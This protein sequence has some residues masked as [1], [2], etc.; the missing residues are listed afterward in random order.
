MKLRILVVT[1]ISALGSGCSTLDDPRFA[2]QIQPLLSI[3]HGAPNA[4]AFYQLGRYYQ[5]QFRLVQAEEAYLKAIAADDHYVDA[6]NA[7]GSLYAERGDLER[8]AKMFEQVT[9][10][11]PN[12]AYLYNNLGFAYYL[13]GRFEEAYVNVRKALSLDGSIERGWVNLERIASMFPETKLLADIK[14]RRVDRLPTELAAKAITEPTATET[15]QAAAAPEIIPKLALADTLAT[16]AM[17]PNYED[18]VVAVK[19]AGQMPEFVKSNEPPITDGKFVLVSVTPDVMANGEPTDT[20]KAEAS[21]DRGDTAVPTARLEVTNGNGVTRFA[22]NFSAKLRGKNIPVK[23]ITNLG[24]FSLKTTVIEYQPGYEDAARLLMYRTKLV[25]RL[26]P[27]IK[28]RP[29]S[30]IRIVLGK[31]ALN[32]S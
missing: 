5:G 10:M 7:L 14:S 27:A 30:D 26:I 8:S 29:G 13:Q 9:A 24:S 1:L 23:R 18:A 11:A 2:L 28:L 25:A 12:A 31:D 32:F 21:A 3:R 4:Q 19:P 20:S 17:P 15:V 22:R 6:Y 16:Q